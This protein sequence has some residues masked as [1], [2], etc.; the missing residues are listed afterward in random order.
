M[1]TLINTKYINDVQFTGDYSISKEEFTAYSERIKSQFIKSIKVDGFRPGKVPIEKAMAQ[2]DPVKLS[3]TTI[4]ETIQKFLPSGVEAIK[5]ELEKNNKTPIEFEASLGSSDLGMQDDG[6]FIFR[7]NVKTLPNIDLNKIKNLKFPTAD[8]SEILIERKSKADFVALETAK[9]LENLNGELKNKEL[10]PCKDIDSALA[11]LPDAIGVFQSA[12]KVNE[13]LNG[14]WDYE[15]EYLLKE[16]KQRK[17]V[18]EVL[19]NTADFDL[20]SDPITAE[21]DRIAKNIIEDSEKEKKT[22]AEIFEAAGLPNNKKIKITDQDSLKKAITYYVQS[23][24]KLMW[25]LRTVYELETTEK[26]TEEKINQIARDME[27]NPQS[28]RLPPEL[29]QEMYTNLAFDRLMRNSAFETISAWAIGN[30]T[31]QSKTTV[32]ESEKKEIEK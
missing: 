6:T 4:T 17:L 16:V 9:I 12:E 5:Q 27:Q 25:T 15:T 10:E 30:S 20:N 26:V 14:V 31:S 13:S 3:Q 1:A 8:I 29:G 32:I 23:E 11:L 19:E 21:T 18:K 24:Y 7:I 28:Y 2:I 22:L